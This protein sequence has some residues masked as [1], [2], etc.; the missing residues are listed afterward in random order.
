MK[1]RQDR[2]KAKPPT[3]FL[4]CEHAGNEVPRAYRELFSKS[5]AILETHRGW[6]PGAFKIASELS[7]ISRA[8][9][10][11]TKVSR[12]IVDT[13]RSLQSETLFSKL[14][15]GLEAAK[16]DQI[17][18]HFYLPYRG[19]VEK[20]VESELRRSPIAH[21]GIHSF[22][23]YLDP[24]RRGCHIGVLFDPKSRFETDLANHLFRHLE[25][26]FPKL[27]IRKN[28]PYRGDADGLTTDLRKKHARPNRVARYAGLEI[29]FNQ[30]FLR[31]LEAQNSTREFAR[32][33]HFALESA[34]LDL[35]RLQSARRGRVSLPIS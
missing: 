27:G 19:R 1:Q 28:F 6:D 17:L 3:L 32:I 20:A 24:A 12:L 9:F 30:A 2:H 22:S 11:F 26:L 35:P 21:F 13:N 4:T 18:R 14:T 33:F 25:V 7:K 16:K 23:P 5:P 34:L 15:A 29:E 31:K 10:Y 8:P